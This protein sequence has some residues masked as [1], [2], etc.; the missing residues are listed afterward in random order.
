MDFQVSGEKEWEDTLVTVVGVC[1]GHL[2][3]SHSQSEAG[4]LRMAPVFQ[5]PAIPADTSSPF[6]G[7]R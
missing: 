4:F 1:V 3:G 5:G 2:V 6:Q 7:N